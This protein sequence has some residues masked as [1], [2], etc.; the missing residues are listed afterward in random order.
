MISLSYTTIYTYKREPPSNARTQI[1]IGQS[2]LL[3]CFFRTCERQASFDRV[4][5][6]RKQKNKIRII[7]YT[8]A[9]RSVRFLSFRERQSPHKSKC[10]YCVFTVFM[11]SACDVFSKFSFFSLWRRNVIGQNSSPEKNHCTVKQIISGFAVN[12]RVTLKSDK[13][14][15]KIGF[16]KTTMKIIRVSRFIIFCQKRCLYEIVMKFVVTNECV[17]IV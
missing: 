11:C 4:P 3:M 15:V 16:E 10:C 12:I 5:I 14:N 17:I 1:Y 8:H 13:T 7:Q 6:K 2:W 9:K